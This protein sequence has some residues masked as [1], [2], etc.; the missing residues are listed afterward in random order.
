MTDKLKPCPFCGSK[1]VGIFDIHPVPLTRV[2]CLECGGNG[3]H[4]KENE[5]AID[6]WNQRA[7][8]FKVETTEKEDIGKSQFRNT[9]YTIDEV[10]DRMKRIIREAWTP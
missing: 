4:E 7:D 6:K 10:F 9:K 2:C 3:S 8:I 5:R 1:E